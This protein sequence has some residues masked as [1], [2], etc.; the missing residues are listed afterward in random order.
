MFGFITRLIGVNACPDC[1]IIGGGFAYYRKRIIHFVEL[2][3]YFLC[4]CIFF[5]TIS[6]VCVCMCV[7][8]FIYVR[9]AVLRTH[10]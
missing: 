5:C 7:S 2:H 10:I 6:C 1:L 9:S 4:M 8:P 3:F